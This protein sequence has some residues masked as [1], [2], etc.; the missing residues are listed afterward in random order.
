MSD[1]V[2]RD[3]EVWTVE[4]DFSRRRIGATVHRGDIA[5]NLCDVQRPHC[6]SAMTM[7]DERKHWLDDAVST[8]YPTMK[9][10]G[11]SD[12]IS[13]VRDDERRTE[14][15]ARRHSIVSV[16]DD[17]R[18]RVKRWDLVRTRRRMTSRSTGSVTYYRLRT[19][20]RKKTGEAMR[21]RSYATTKDEWKYWLGDAVSSPYATTK[22]DG[23][24]E[25][26]SFIHDDERRAEV[27]A[28]WRSIIAVRNNERWRVKRWDLVNQWRR[29]YDSI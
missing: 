15:L 1:A 24:S 21:S 12:E 25:E 20:R 2:L 28:R 13:S 7:K 11:W 6:D 9:D 29:W 5:S 19:R 16:R 3:V 27:L 14:V 22:D 10:D 4:V 18:W 8:P 23:W 26:I 17:E